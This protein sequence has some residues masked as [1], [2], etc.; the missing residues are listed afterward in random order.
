[1]DS[2]NFIMWFWIMAALCLMFVLRNILILKIVQNFEKFSF[3]GFLI[4]FCIFVLPFI[5]YGIF[6]HI[7][8][9]V[10]STRPAIDQMENTVSI[11]SERVMYKMFHDDPE[12]P[13]KRGYWDA[14][15]HEEN[16]DLIIVDEHCRLHTEADEAVKGIINCK[17]PISP[18]GREYYFATEKVI[19][20]EYKY[21]L[22]VARALYQ[23]NPP[24][25]DY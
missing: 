16:I 5:V 14:P 22:R 2:G 12:G 11:A 7:H 21:S 25:V 10:P 17:Y 1:M 3:A 19:G 6:A 23:G 8:Y 13:F 24:P 4:L 9:F 15:H 20:T 18:K